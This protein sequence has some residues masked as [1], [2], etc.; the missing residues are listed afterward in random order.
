MPAT[1]RANISFNAQPS[2]ARM[3]QAASNSKQETIAN[4]ITVGITGASP[5]DCVLVSII[6]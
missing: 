1:V 3:Q 5:L 4:I 2:S 6:L